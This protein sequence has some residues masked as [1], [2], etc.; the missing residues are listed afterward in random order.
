VDQ[1]SKERQGQ[2]LGSWVQ[3]QRPKGTAL[4]SLVGGSGMCVQV[5]AQ[6]MEAPCPVAYEGRMGNKWWLR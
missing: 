5:R 4:P 1:R 2:G 6:A 3:D